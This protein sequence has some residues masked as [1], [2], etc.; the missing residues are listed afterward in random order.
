MWLD[1]DSLSWGDAFPAELRSTI[2]SGVDFL[3]IFLDNDALRSEWVKRELKWAIEREKEL[4]RTFVLPIVLEE[5][6]SEKLPPGF[7]ERLYLRLSDFTRASVES[8]AKIATE[9]LFQL[10]IES[11]SAVQLE[12]P[13]RE[14]LG[15]IQDQLSAGQSRLL[16][17]V[18][19]QCKGGSEVMQHE[20][21]SA[22]GYPST[23]LHYR[24][25]TLVAQG[26][27]LK[28]RMTDGQFIYRLSDD[29]KKEVRDV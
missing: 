16:G 18:I 15:T 19:Q 12:R 29:Y 8:L 2:Q 11:F 24:L 1:E 26:F 13:R 6:P 9:K 5:I 21:E 28:R 10:V 22:M 27:L 14:S 23:E 4:K 3:I 7:S 17:H 20:I 25:E